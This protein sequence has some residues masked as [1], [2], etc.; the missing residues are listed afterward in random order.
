MDD[1]TDWQRQLLVGLA[2]LVAVGALIGGIVALISIK[3]ADYAGIDGGSKTSAATNTDTA[4]EPATVPPRTTSH[5]N[6]Q[7]RAVH[8]RPPPKRPRSQ[9]TRASPSSLHPRASP[10]SAGSTSPAPTPAGPARPCRCSGWKAASGSTSPRR[11]QS[12]VAHSRPTSR[13]D[14]QAPTS[15]GSRRSAS[16]R[17]RTPSRCESPSESGQPATTSMT[18]SAI[19][20]S[21]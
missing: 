9:P 20:A 15:S 10:P 3:A 5:Q 18:G 8:R 14:V 1:E 16:R 7:S 12:T 13:R 6:R 19:S 11:R 4:S 21:R 2:V 17:R